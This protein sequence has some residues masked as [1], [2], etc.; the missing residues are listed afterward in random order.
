MNIIATIRTPNADYRIDYS[1]SV[2]KSTMEGAWEYYG[3]C[4][5]PVH[6]AVTTLQDR[7]RVYARLW[8]YSRT[9]VSA[10]YKWMK[11]STELS[12]PNTP[13]IFSIACDLIQCAF[14]KEKFSSKEE[15][16][17]QNI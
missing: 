9:D 14:E 3:P 6:A 5:G 1:G 15:C 8:K 17:V 4:I 16:H 7:T 2:E 11:E 12:V 13:I 10:A